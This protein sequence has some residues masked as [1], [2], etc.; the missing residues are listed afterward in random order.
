M[1]WNGND[2]T[3]S[4]LCASSHVLW[5]RAQRNVKKSAKIFRCATTPVSSPTNMTIVG[6]AMM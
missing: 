5:P 2:A 6:M 4:R 3:A 1:S